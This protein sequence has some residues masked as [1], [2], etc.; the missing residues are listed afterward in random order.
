MNLPKPTKWAT[1]KVNNDFICV[2]TESGYRGSSLDTSG[3]QTL[4][5]PP[6]LPADLGQAVIDSLY[7]SRMLRSSEEID[8]FFSLQNV[9]KRYN[10]WVSE[11]MSLYG[12][13]NKNS[14]F[15]K[16]KNCFVESF[17]EL[18]YFKPSHHEK[19]E[20][21]TGKGISE[22]DWVIIPKHSTPEEIGQAA[23]LALDRCSG[24]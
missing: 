18:I 1:I 19:L 20:L 17:D 23:L 4:L 24:N 13:T 6:P 12:C 15:K 5:K 21:W 9:T 10:T 11:L 2:S 14:F 22:K 7:A 3:V 8:D 16:M